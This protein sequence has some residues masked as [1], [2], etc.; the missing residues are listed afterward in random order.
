MVS[1]KSGGIQVLLYRDHPPSRQVCL[2]PRCMI[3]YPSH[4][5]PLLNWMSVQILKTGPTVLFNTNDRTNVLKVLGECTL[6][7]EVLA[8][9]PQLLLTGSGNM[10][11]WQRHN[12][13]LP[14]SVF[15]ADTRDWCHKHGCRIWLCHDNGL[16]LRDLRLSHNRRL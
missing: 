6:T 9:F 2:S 4:Q 12:L 8:K 1:H 14:Q 5:R 3:T 15:C 16:W 7:R 13:S 10:P 11:S